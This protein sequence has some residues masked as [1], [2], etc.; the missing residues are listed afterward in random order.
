MK[1]AAGKSVV[2]VLPELV[3][4]ED[5]IAEQLASF[6]ARCDRRLEKLD[7]KLAVLNEKV[8]MVRRDPNCEGA[9]PEDLD[10]IARLEM[11]L[12]MKTN[13]LMELVG[14]IDRYKKQIVAQEGVYNSMFG[15]SPAVALLRPQTSLP[16]GVRRH[17]KPQRPQTA[18][19][20]LRSLSTMR[21][22]RISE[23]YG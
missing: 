1:A 15:A 23:T 17:Q 5:G 7:A 13:H 12:A 11:T 22:R 10:V 14:D 16:G 19:P 6:R 4:S 9:R 20:V 2:I 8:K 21:N 3:P 18:S